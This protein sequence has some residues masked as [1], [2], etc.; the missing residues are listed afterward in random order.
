MKKYAFIIL[1]LVIQGAV[2]ANPVV[3]SEN[4]KFGL[5]NEVGEIITE[6]KYKKL[7]QLGES[8]WII[9]SGS[10]FGIINNEGQIVVSPKYNRA[11]RVLGKYVKLI[12]GEKCGLFDEKG[13]EVL[14]VEYTSIDLLYGGMFLTCKNFKYGVTDHNGILILDNVF[15]DIYMPKP[16][17]MHLV[18]NGQ[19]FEIEGVGVNG[20][21]NELT[22][23]TD[24]TTLADNTNFS[25]T[26]LI[27]NP[28]TTTGY[29]GVTA[30]DYFLKLFSSIS[31]AYEDTIDELMFAQGADAAGV[32]LKFT[33]LP[34]FPFVYA[35]KYYQNL[36]A[37]NNGPLNGVKTH[38][39]HK[40]DS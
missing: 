23:P 38:L 22:L 34:R 39:K 37:P 18:Y 6:A 1:L 28:V 33:W 5:K 4:G 16:N 15:D 11:D 29:Y 17:V 10:K 3:Y 24:I 25:I 32:I 9:Q 36:T 13:L 27:T 12:K 2:F 31:S 8:G 30:T 14:P 21:K 7:I 35:K 40:L 20:N 19:H 26:E